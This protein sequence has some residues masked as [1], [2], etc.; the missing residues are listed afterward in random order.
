MSNLDFWN[1]VCETDKNHTKHVTMRG[2]FTSIDPQYQIRMATEKFGMYG[3][4]WGFDS[5]DYDYSIMDNG[6]VLVKAVFF[7]IVD[8]EK[9]TFPINNSWQMNSGSKIDPEFAK[10]AETNTMSKALSKL[11]F[12]A[13]VYMGMFDDNEYLETLDAK[14]RLAIAES[15][16]DDGELRKINDE[17]NEW[18]KKEIDS[19]DLAPNEQA[20]ARMADAIKRKASDK[21]LINKF[22][23]S[24]KLNVMQRIHSK[25]EVVIFKLRNKGDQNG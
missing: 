25:A 24:K 12:N 10:K 20:V 5:I 7:Y 9:S 22:T 1:S 15:M 18:C 11:G 8:G 23:D 19:L 4:F 3:K 13:D 14:K 6:L 2:G 17:F 21:M 16:E